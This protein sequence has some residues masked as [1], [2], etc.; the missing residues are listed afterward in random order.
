MLTKRIIPCL[1]VQGGRVVKNVRFFEDH[2]DAGDPLTLAQAY[3]AQQADELV[4]YDITATHEG[5]ALMLDVAA[6]VAEQAE[7][8]QTPGIG[9]TRAPVR[10]VDPVALVEQ[11]LA[12]VGAILTRGAGDDR[13]LH[14]HL[15]EAV[16]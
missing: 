2:R 7:L 14:V 13:T 16:S 15:L 11:G 10:G 4:F 12:K 5:R 1:D 6:R 8:A 9:G 3:E